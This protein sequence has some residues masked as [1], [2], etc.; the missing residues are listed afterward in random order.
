MEKKVNPYSAYERETVINFSDADGSAEIYTAS[1]H[2]IKKLDKLC[3]EHPDYYQILKSDEWSKT[4]KIKSKKL[5][6]FAKPPR[7]LSDEEKAAIS[8]RLANYRKK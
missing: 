6:K 3:E 4:Y 1:T 7:Q 2:T 8:A 5:I